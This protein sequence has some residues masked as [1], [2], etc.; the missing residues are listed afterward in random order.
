MPEHEFSLTDLFPHKNIIVDSV[1]TREKMGQRK[2]IFHILIHFLNL[3]IHSKCGKISTKITLN[4]DTF[5]AVMDGC[6]LLWL[7]LLCFNCT[8]IY[9][10]NFNLFRIKFISLCTLVNL[11]YALCLHSYSKLFSNFIKFKIIIFLIVYH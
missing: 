9:K 8:V 5:H 4:T 7:I 3:C 10:R 1:V 2:T 6:Y 11:T